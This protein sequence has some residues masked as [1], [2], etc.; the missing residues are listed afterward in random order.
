MEIYDANINGRLQY[1]VNCKFVTIDEVTPANPPAAIIYCE[2]RETKAKV[3]LQMLIKDNIILH[4]RDYKTS[5][6][7]LTVLNNLYQMENSNRILFLKS[8]L[9][10]V[11][12]QHNEN[13]CAYLSRVKELRDK[14]GNIGENES[15][16]DIVT[17]T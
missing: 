10:S 6:E 17:V 9:P 8:E 7:T 13:I 11:K 4:S 1:L 3:L 14:L 15:S 12:M 2:K 16:N 5:I